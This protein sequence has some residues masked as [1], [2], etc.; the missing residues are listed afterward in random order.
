MLPD[1]TP[2][3]RAAALQK[4]AEARHT[5]AT[6]R[7]R[8]K[9]GGASVTEILLQGRGDDAIGR[10]RVSALMESMPGIGKARARAIM[11]EL[12]IAEGRRI[13]G[14]GVQQLRAIANYFEG[15]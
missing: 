13:R 4:A 11:E 6:V 14:L 9:A 10:M 2:E 5:R 12:G 15:A 1:Q 8:L 7:Q 3:A